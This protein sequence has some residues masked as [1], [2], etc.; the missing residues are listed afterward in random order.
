MKRI[1]LIRIIEKMERFLLD[2]EVITTG[3]K[4]RELV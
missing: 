1:D 2:T 3:I 4:T